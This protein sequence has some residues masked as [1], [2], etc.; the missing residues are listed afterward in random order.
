MVR[1][2]GSGNSTCDVLN[3]KQQCYQLDSDVRLS[4][5]DILSS[6]YAELCMFA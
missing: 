1:V 2:L 3:R 5:Y 4:Q 6:F